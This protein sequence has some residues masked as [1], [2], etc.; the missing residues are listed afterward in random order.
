MIQCL[1]RWFCFGSSLYD[2]IVLIHVNL[3]VRYEGEDELDQFI[4]ATFTPLFQLEKALKTNQALVHLT[5][6][7]YAAAQAPLLALF[8]WSRHYFFLVEM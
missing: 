7:L 4:H 6:Y 5:A 2:V 8:E 3:Q 1:L